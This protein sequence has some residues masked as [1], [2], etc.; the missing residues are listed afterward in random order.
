M[1]QY[2]AIDPII[3]S[4]GPLAIRWYGLTYVIAFAVAWWLGRRRAAQP[5]STWKPT[6]VDDLIFYGALGV[7]LGG[8]IGWVLFYG[9]ERLIDDPLMILRIWEGG[10]SF[11]G[12]LVGVILAEILFARRQRRR[13]VD[14]LDFLAPLPGIGIFAVRCANFINGELWGKPTQSPWGFI[15]D[16]A[17]LHPSQQAEALRMCERFNIDPCVLHV[18]AS[19]L[20]EGVLE[21]LVVFVI[22]WIYTMKPRPRL[23]PAGLFLLCYGVFRFAVEF[24]RV[25]DENRGYLLFD[26]VTMGQILSTPMIVA[27]L[28]MLIVAYRRN[29]PSG[30]FAT[31]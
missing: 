29:E 22:L 15:V 9:F 17:T 11:H 27:G 10:M 6:D 31:K 4:L 16:P 7:I 30:N 18:H 2:P 24:V 21:G 25:P 20:Y 8:R 1:I 14:V 3:V 5:G 12:G 26:W 28:I 23:A 19:Q 13:I